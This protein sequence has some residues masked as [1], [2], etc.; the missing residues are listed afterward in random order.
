MNSLTDK[1]VCQVDSIYLDFRKAFDRVPHL[2]LLSKLK[3]S[4]ISG[5]LLSWFRC[6]LSNRKQLVSI[7]GSHSSVL[8]VSSGVPQGS[9]LGP[10]LF[11]VYINDLPNTI[12]PFKVFL[13]ADD[14]KCCHPVSSILNCYQLQNC[15]DKLSDWSERWNLHFNESKCVTMNFQK[16][17][18]SATISYD[19][20]VGSNVI[21]VS[22]CHSDLGVLLQ[23]NLNWASQYNLMCS[24]AYK[25][26]NM[27]RRSFSSSNSVVTRRS[28][29]IALV[30]SQMSYCSQLWRP[31]LIKDIKKLESVQRR[32]TKFIIG[33]EISGLNYR[34]R[35]IHL[36]LLPLMCYYELLDITFLVN[37]LKNKTER[38]NVLQFVQIQD[39]NTRSSDRVTL[40]HIRCESN[41]QE[42]F[43]FNRVARL[44]NKMPAIDLSLSVNTIRT[45]LYKVMWSSFI[46][47]FS[48]DNACSFHFKCPCSRCHIR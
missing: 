3:R 48:G 40:K 1:R 21:P 33:S 35:L 25:V 36:N 31:L 28:L 29:Y 13:F 5:R 27:V 15:L 4:G 39:L 44:W 20:R 22:E 37:S 46:N 10:L 14:T 30:R 32:A 43:Y 9:I 19:Y 38:F 34:E 8:P 47:N 42:H 16:P 24:K 11:L 2:E 23:S 26:L 18:K 6:Y 7:N 45:K 12:T 17:T 41:L